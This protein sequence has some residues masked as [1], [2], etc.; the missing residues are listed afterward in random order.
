MQRKVDGLVDNPFVPTLDIAGLKKNVN[1]LHCLQFARAAMDSMTGEAIRLCWRKA[2]F[3]AAAGTITV[4]R[5]AQDQPAKELQLE[6][7]IA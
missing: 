4:E 7:D 1:I 6:A 2:G 5:E 3:A